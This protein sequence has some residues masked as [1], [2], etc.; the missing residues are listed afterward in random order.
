[1]YVYLKPFLGPF[2]SN[3]GMRLYPMT[4]LPSKD[5]SCSQI[6]LKG[7]TDY[8]TY[9]LFLFIPDA[10]GSTN[11]YIAM[12]DLSNTSDKDHQDDT[13]SKTINKNK[14]TLNDFDGEDVDVSGQERDVATAVSNA[15]GANANINDCDVEKN[16]PNIAECRSSSDRKQSNRTSSMVQRNDESISESESSQET[17]EI[18]TG[19]DEVNRHGMAIGNKESKEINRFKFIVILILLAVAVISS[20]CVV[21]FIRKAEQNDFE[22]KFQSEALKVLESVRNS[23]D[24]T[25][26]PLDNLAVALVSHAK[27]H[28]D[29]WPFVTLEDFAV[30]VAKILPLTDAIWITVLPVVTPEKRS[31]WENYSSTHDE[32]VVEAVVVQDTWELYYGPKNLTYDPERSAE[33]GGI[34]GPL[35]ANIRCD[36]KR[37]LIFFYL[38]DQN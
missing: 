14:A 23:I 37:G 36:F 3:V 29:E 33:V 30:R 34:F 12:M 32:W 10:R 16:L 25:L 4:S 13:S 20:T 24:N 11:T 38:E 31:Q 22:E 7:D 21:V 26:I 18:D 5:K 15:C 17:K 1:M 27:A 6:S 19:G 35:E 2:K 8:L 9:S 28:T